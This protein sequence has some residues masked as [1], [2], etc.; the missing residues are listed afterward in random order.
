MSEGDLATAAFF[1]KW[2]DAGMP[3][4][5]CALALQIAADVIED[6][7]AGRMAPVQA[8]AVRIGTEALLEMKAR[9]AP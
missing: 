5:D 3:P 6:V 8:R 1:K 7:A 4:S 9:C 2:T